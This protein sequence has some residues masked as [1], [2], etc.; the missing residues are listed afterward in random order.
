MAIQEFRRWTE[1]GPAGPAIHALLE[2]NDGRIVAH[3]CLLPLPLQGPE[4][5]LTVA[6]EHY[7]FVSENYRS[8]LVADFESCTKPAVALLLEQLHER[9]AQLGWDPVL[10]CVPPQLEPIH[11][12]LGCRAVDFRVRDCF[13]L[14][15][16][17]RAWEV[18]HHLPLRTRLSLSA[19][20][21]AS[22]A[23]A[24]YVSAFAPHHGLVRYSRIGDDGMP[25]NGHSGRLAFSEDP[26]F[27]RWRYPEASHSRLVVNDGSEGYAI[28]KKGS[29]FTCVRISQFRAPSPSSIPALVQK[30]IREARGCG[31]LG[32]RWSIYGNG[33][34]QDYLVA[35]LR[36]RL[37]FCIRRTRRVLLSGPNSKTFS[38][39]SWSVADSLF[40][41]DL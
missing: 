3:C 41:F 18:M 22:E 23:Y 14:L 9:A 25:S 30:L 39:N 33:P 8:Q 6:K 32:V 28:V 11:D 19:A 27:L 12:I 15:H 38:A 1:Q 21:L 24:A 26:A 29:P 10:A 34:E 36:K 13:F 4:G 35:E 20:G 5:S 37:F 17:R 40:T 7:F 16:V 31:A 2:G